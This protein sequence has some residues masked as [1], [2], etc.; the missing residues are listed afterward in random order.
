MP[1][2]NRFFYDQDGTTSPLLLQ[3]AGPI[4][5][6]LIHAPAA[7]ARTLAAG[8]DVIPAPQAGLALI[9]TGASYTCVHEPTLRT[10]GL[11]PIGTVLSGTAAGSVQHSRYPARLEFPGE[12]IDQEFSAVTGVDL[13]GQ[14]VL[15]STGPAPIIALIGRDLMSGWV[16]TYNGVGG[17][18]TISF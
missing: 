14:E 16:F 6:V 5:N 10:L 4:L 11:N 3:Q 18:I 15:L 13:N 8:G 17:F 2:R 1:S 12:G 9:D 7:L